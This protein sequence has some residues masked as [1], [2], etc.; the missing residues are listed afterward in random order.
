[1]GEEFADRDLSESVFWGVNLQNTLFR[2]ADL[3]GSTFFHTQWTGVEI[4]GVVERLVVNGVDVTDFVNQ[5]DR[6]YPLRTQLS[7][8]SAEGIR[9]AW[10]TLRVEWA[11]L[12][13]EVDELDADVALESVN[14][15]WS[16]R[17]TLRHLI[18]AIEK[19]FT[20]PVLG[21]TSFTSCALPNKGSQ[22]LEWPGLNLAD[23]PAFEQAREAWAHTADQ[24]GAYV[25]ALDLAALPDTVEVMENGTVP[26]LV[27]FHVV[28]EE[29]FEHLRY[30]RRD[31]A[32]LT[33]L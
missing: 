23:A 27:C 3:S 16:L 19:W 20:V 17:D 13:A 32:A 11:K 9:R 18:F 22:G 15:E 29:S 2:D 1:M 25:A 30:A 21:A 12:L 4:D 8:E 7:P 10:V 5:H 14:G 24:F 28:L 33:S 31:L 26:S 6:W